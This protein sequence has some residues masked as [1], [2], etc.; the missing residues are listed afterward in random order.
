MGYTFFYKAGDKELNFCLLFKVLFSWCLWYR[1]SA[2]CHTQCSKRFGSK[3][4]APKHLSLRRSSWR[5]HIMPLKSFDVHITYIYWYRNSINS[6]RSWEAA[7][8]ISMKYPL[9]SFWPM[10]WDRG[11]GR[12]TG[13]LGP[14]DLGTLR[15]LCKGEEPGSLCSCSTASAP[16]WGHWGARTQFAAT[17]QDIWIP[18][19]RAERTNSGVP[20][21]LSTTTTLL[22]GSLVSP[23]SVCHPQGVTLMKNPEL[24][25]RSSG[26]ASELPL[27]GRR[28]RSLV[29]RKK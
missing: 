20:G 6:L 4:S 14:A 29:L 1:S 2:P 5:G 21:H 13:V 28:V 9:A 25:W 12:W 26:E 3:D 27:Q 16:L 22:F 24:P 19:W 10:G 18:F 7:C 15:L 11:T 17:F 8:T 23:G